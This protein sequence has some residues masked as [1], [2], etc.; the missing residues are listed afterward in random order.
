MSPLAWNHRAN[1]R[2][3]EADLAPSPPKRNG[4]L[5]GVAPE[6]QAVADSLDEA[7]D[8]L[9]T[10][11]RFPKS[12]WKSIRTSNAIERHKEFKRRIKTQTVLP[13]AETAAP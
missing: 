1:K 9:F 3:L 6:V 13:S 10:I 8:K 4:R 11:T 7:G 12:Q 5:Y 2:S